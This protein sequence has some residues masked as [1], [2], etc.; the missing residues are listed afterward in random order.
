MVHIPL[1]SSGG[2]PEEKGWGGPGVGIVDVI[3]GVSLLDE[4]VEV[5]VPDLDELYTV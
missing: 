5:E 4:L 3:V 1:G 2:V